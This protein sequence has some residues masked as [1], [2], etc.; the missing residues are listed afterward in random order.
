MTFHEY[1][2]E[3]EKIVILFHPSGT[4]WDYFE[5]VIPYLEK[6]CH[7]I[8]PA[9]PGYDKEH[10]EENFTS[11]EQIADEVEDWL[12]NKGITTVDNI[13]GCSMGGSLVVRMLATSK[14]T[15]KSA[16][17]DGGITPYQLPWIITRFIAVKDWMLIWSGKLAGPRILEKAFAA[18]NYSKEDLQYI[19]DVLS[20]M[21]NKTIWRTFE[22]C[23]NYSMP[24]TIPEYKG[25]LEY[26]CADK[27]IGDRKWDIRYM[28]E[29]F[30]GVHFKK[31]KDLGHGGMAAIRPEEFA[32]RIRK[33]IGA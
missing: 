4:M 25:I 29:H 13:Y 10:P 31:M 17:V 20:F 7:L 22:S 9:L 5:Y 8:I 27:E 33:L 18:D 19:A 26:W 6:H 1:G 28:K 32:K 21:S 11:I 30:S 14:L 23:N 12:T 16:V 2:Q 24:E 15:I 3:N